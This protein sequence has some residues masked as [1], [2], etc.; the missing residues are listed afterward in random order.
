[1]KIVVNWA[2]C[3]GNGACAKVAP[4]LFALDVNDTLQ[5]LK[6]NFGEDHRAKA[7]AAVLACPKTALSLAEEDFTPIEGTGSRARS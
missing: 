3:D 6:E 4:E 1:M 2:L 7:E 5:L